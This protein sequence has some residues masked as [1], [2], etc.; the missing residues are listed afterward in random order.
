M[1]EQTGLLVYGF[2]QHSRKITSSLRAIEFV[3]PD[4]KKNYTNLRFL[5]VHILI[6]LSAIHCMLNFNEWSQKD[7]NHAY[8]YLPK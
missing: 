6:D 1:G 5:Y 2:S 3:I 7:G 4:P 8:R